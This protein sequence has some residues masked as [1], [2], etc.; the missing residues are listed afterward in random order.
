MRKSRDENATPID[1]QYKAKHRIF[2]SPVIDEDIV[3]CSQSLPNGICLIEVS[4]HLAVRSFCHQL[5]DHLV[6]DAVCVNRMGGLAIGNRIASAATGCTRI[7]TGVAPAFRKIPVGD[8]VGTEFL[9]AVVHEDPS[10][11]QIDLD[12]ISS[13]EISAQLGHEALGN[14]LV[15]FLVGH[16]RGICTRA[17]RELIV[18]P[19]GSKVLTGPP[20]ATSAVGASAAATTASATLKVSPSAAGPGDTC[21]P[22]F[23]AIVDSHLVVIHKLVTNRVGGLEIPIFLGLRPLFY[24][25]FDSCGVHVRVVP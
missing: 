23:L 8:T 2:H 22:G 21:P 9:Y 15:D 12:G 11:Y 5:V 17:F 25:V 3:L 20:T 16:S 7:S 4:H 10:S 18:V 13:P 24:H 6:I 14:H 19:V 1:I